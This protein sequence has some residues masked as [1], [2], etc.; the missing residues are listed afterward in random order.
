MAYSDNSPEGQGHQY[1]PPFVVTPDMPPTQRA[2]V[3]RVGAEY[4]QLCVDAMNDALAGRRLDLGELEA[5]PRYN[6]GG[7]GLSGS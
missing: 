7:P 1:T 5:T 2:E 6:D 3:D 4:G